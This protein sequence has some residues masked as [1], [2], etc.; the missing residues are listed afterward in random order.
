MRP[1]LKIGSRLSWI[2]AWSRVAAAIGMTLLW[3]PPPSL[4]AR[5]TPVGCGSDR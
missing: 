1:P 4:W 2:V 3:G 5:L